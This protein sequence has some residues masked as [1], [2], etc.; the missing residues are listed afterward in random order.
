MTAKTML[1]AALNYASRGIPVLPV[2]PATTAPLVKRER[3]HD[4]PSPPSSTDEAVIRG[5]WTRFP[6]AAVAIPTGRASG[7]F[8]LKISPPDALDPQARLSQM[9]A[10]MIAVE[11]ELGVELPDTA[12]VETPEGARLLFFI[13][14]DE[15]MP[16]SRSGLVEGTEVRGDGGHA[17]LPPSVRENA[18]AYVW[19]HSPDDTPPAEPPAVLLDWIFKLGRFAAKAPKKPKKNRSP[20]LLGDAAMDALEGHPLPDV[21]GD[22]VQAPK[23]PARQP[24]SK[25]KAPRE[26]KPEGKVDYNN[27]IELR[28]A[29]RSN[30]NRED[31]DPHFP[32]G[33]ASPGKWSPNA[34]GLPLEDP[35][36]AIPLGIAGDVFWFL[37]SARQLRQFRASQL[38]HAGI[39]DLFAAQPN[40]PE[41]AWPRWSKPKLDSEGNVIEPPEI[42]SFEDDAVRKALFRACE[43]MDIFSPEQMLRGRGMWKREDGSC[44]YH[45][46]QEL[47]EFRDGKI[48]MLECGLHQDGNEQHVYP[49]LRAL[50]PPWLPPITPANNP[51]R[52]LVLGFRKWNW[53]MPAVAP[54]LLLGWIGV[55]YLG[56]ALDWRSTVFL[57]GDKRTGKSTLQ[58]FLKDVFGDALFDRADTTA[59]D[60]YQ[61]L[62]SDVRPVAVDEIEGG[63][64]NDKATKVMELARVAASGAM[65]GRGGSEGHGTEFQLRSAFLFSAINTPPLMPQDLS[66]M[67][68]LRLKKLSTESAGAPPTIDAEAC[69]RMVLA[70]LIREFHRFP[71][72]YAK[73]RATLAAGGHD[74]RGQDTYGTLLACA[75]LILGPELAEELEI[76]MGEES[77]A[78]RELLNIENLPEVQGSEDNWLA[79]VS[80]L[81]TA[82][83]DI[84]RNGARVTVGELLEEF[85]ENGKDEGRNQKYVKKDLHRAGL[86]IKQVE[87]VPGWCLCV[88]NQSQ[89][90]ARLFYGS[91]WQGA[92][93][94]GVWESALRQGLDSGCIITDRK[95]NRERINFKQFRCTL[96]VLDKIDGAADPP[97]E[98]APAPVSAS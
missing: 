79:C 20:R 41:W 58:A 65:G 83:T 24:R 31:P 27:P 44:I 53:E 56:G 75:D 34:L 84:S 66:R 61:K 12:T 5:W 88:P 2:N 17:L 77:D 15:R 3:G 36:P 21:A 26:E 95:V 74:G 52:E 45:A 76:P 71:E 59:A 16:K 94:A 29:A 37:D 46:G 69:G 73:Y 40:W 1:E 91:R 8:V 60:I 32:R 96:I 23:P 10:R 14:P 68:L 86:S 4:D 50:P 30:R 51:A 18:G 63:P 43:R 38:N 25:D 80:H 89:Q 55:A 47:W 11:N 92:T 28:R 70:Q 64:H 42:K 78:W 35:C 87:G 13:A 90:V 57:I 82:P 7:L 81:L 19:L 72:I 49:R 97:D 39:Q 62:G 6:L 48:R 22:G 85:Q 54:V 33:G 67:A 9:L 93:G 98:R